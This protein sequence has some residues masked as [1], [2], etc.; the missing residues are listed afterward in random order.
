M[1]DRKRPTIGR[2]FVEKFGDYIIALRNNEIVEVSKDDEQTIIGYNQLVEK[3]FAEKEELYDKIRYKATQNGYAAS[4][5]LIAI[6]GR[7]KASVI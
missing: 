3:G 4:D 1:K 2:D 7:D 5:R 6:R